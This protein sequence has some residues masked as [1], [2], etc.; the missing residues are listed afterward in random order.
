MQKILFALALLLCARPMAAQSYL[1]YDAKYF[2]TPLAIPTFDGSY[3]AIHP[4]VVD[5]GSAW[6]GYRYWMAYTPYTNGNNQTELPSIVASND[7][8]TW[9]VPTGGANPLQRAP[10]A[11]NHYDDPDLVYDP[12]SDR[13]FLYFIYTYGNG[14]SPCGD[15]AA[16]CFFL[17]TSSD[18]VTWSAK[19]KVLNI[20]AYLSPAIVRRAAN[21]WWLFYVDQGQ[22]PYKIVARR[23]KDGRSWGSALTM[24]DRWTSGFMPWHMEVRWNAGKSRFEMLSYDTYTTNL[25][26]S[27]GFIRAYV[28]GNGTSWTYSD[29]S[30]GS[31]VDWIAYRPGFISNGDGTIDLWY[32]AMDRDRGSWGMLYRASVPQPFDGYVARNRSLQWDFESGIEEFFY[33]G[34]WTA[35]GLTLSSSTAQQEHGTHSLQVSGSYGNTIEAYSYL[36][37]NTAALASDLI[38]KT[39]TAYLYDDMDP[40]EYYVIRL[41]QMD[42][43]NHEAWCGVGAY[44]A[45]SSTHYFYQDFNGNPSSHDTAVARSPGWRRIDWTFVDSTHLTI[46]IDGTIVTTSLS[47]PSGGPQFLDATAYTG[48]AFYID[49]INV[50]VTAGMMPR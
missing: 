32:G 3:Q 47:M 21:D 28:S 4:S 46:A 15:V 34:L 37:Y 12:A 50:A 22:T 5:M 1:S 14:T 36:P 16:S 7:K 45:Q 9:V 17:Q 33:F 43:S 39:L 35:R 40:N 24:T 19:T 10:G 38:G 30:G 31:L 29:A 48:P 41:R 2:G 20:G 44:S 49:N 6:H 25:G 8:R 26:G 11:G 23:S 13:L 27:V 42:T 18:G